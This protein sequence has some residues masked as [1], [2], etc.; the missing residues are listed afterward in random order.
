[1][2]IETLKQFSEQI[3]IRQ[4]IVKG[5][6]ATKQSLILPFLQLLEFDIWNPEE[7]KPEF[8]ADFVKKKSGPQ[9]KVDYAVF[10]N[11]LP[12]ILIEAKAANIK[13]EK[14][15]GQLARYFNSIPSAKVAILT[16]G[17]VYK[18]FTDLTLPNVMDEEP[19][20]EI[21]VLDLS[22]HIDII[23]FYTKTG[24]N[25]SSLKEHTEEVS[26]LNK[27]TT[28]ITKL[29]VEPTPDF[30]KFILTNIGLNVRITEKVIDK[31]TPII[32]K[33]FNAAILK[34]LTESFGK[35]GNQVSKEDTKIITT[36]DELEA[37]NMIKK[38][39]DKSD[40]KIPI[41]Y[42]DTTGYFG[43]NLGSPKKWFVRVFL[44]TTQKYLILRG[45]VSVYK[46][47]ED[48]LSYEEIGQNT[49]INFNNLSDLVFFEKI[50]RKAY[51]LE[52]LSDRSSEIDVTEDLTL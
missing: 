50:I 27:I 29:I 25:T 20:L 9:E 34:K 7:V 3:K 26:S 32:K 52:S 24:I 46:N 13:L 49:K 5:E 10:L 15:S 38:Y 40:I 43:I 41:S 51:E 45:P 28:F 35:E 1:M 31:N 16:N 12:Y 2:K 18:F 33:A 37:F 44:L 21:N 23:K 48:S 14:H 47:L 4:S 8:T 11:G 42:K 17:L 19:Y 30:I 36:S 39:C 22:K 6:E